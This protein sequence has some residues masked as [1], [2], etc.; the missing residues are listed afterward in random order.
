MKAIF[1]NICNNI[2]GADT[3]KPNINYWKNLKS[4]VGGTPVDKEVKAKENQGIA[5]VAEL[6][7][8]RRQA[9]E[10]RKRE[11][12]E[13]R[14]DSN[15]SVATTDSQ[16]SQMAEDIIMP[17]PT[18]GL[19]PSEEESKGSECVSDSSKIEMDELPC[20]SKSADAKEKMSKKDAQSEK[21]A[22]KDEYDRKPLLLPVSQV[23]IASQS[24]EK[25]GQ[26]KFVISQVHQKVKIQKSETE[27]T[28]S[29]ARIILPED[30]TT[31]SKGNLK[32][33]AFNL[34]QDHR[35]ESCRPAETHNILMERKRA[36]FGERRRSSVVPFHPRRM[37]VD[38]RRHSIFP[39]PP[40]KEPAKI[41]GFFGLRSAY[42]LTERLR[43]P[44]PVKQEP[45][46]PKEPEPLNQAEV[47]VRAISKQVSS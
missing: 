13:T 34:P 36:M 10:Q 33:V 14:K 19:L 11:L 2:L 3:A 5:E 9:R 15:M 20:T 31:Q 22:H 44:T 32:G 43:P 12:E 26:V 4:A 40:P 24:E 35:R 28:T 47:Y 8:Q 21:P 45:K 39:R 18:A 41:T 30:S 23:N 1:V 27:Q 29:M 17:S 7:S 16:A 42:S 37:S 38:V 6:L 25:S 46:L